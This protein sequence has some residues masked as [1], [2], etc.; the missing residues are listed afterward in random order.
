MYSSSPVVASSFILCDLFCS[1]Y[2]TDKQYVDLQ[3]M[4]SLRKLISHI[5]QPI[6]IPPENQI[7]G[8]SP[9]KDQMDI[10]VKFF[11][12]AESTCSYLTAKQKKNKYL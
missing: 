7:Y 5:N 1:S 11:A 8:Y 6:H 3:L 9:D 2:Y 4:L 12:P 10:V